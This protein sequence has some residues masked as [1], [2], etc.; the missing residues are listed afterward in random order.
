[1]AQKQ[2][3]LKHPNLEPDKELTA[4]IFITRYENNEPIKGAKVVLTI[5][6]GSSPKQEITAIATDTVGLYEI[7]LPPMP[8]G[9]YK[10]GV[11][12]DVSNSSLA[13]NFGA[14]QVK[15]TPVE[16]PADGTSWARTVLI[17]LGVLLLLALLGT[18][19]LVAVQ[20]GRREKRVK[21]ETVTA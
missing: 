18:L 8:Q 13:A 7:K 20:Y 11:H 10:L 21:E 19:L 14:V 3:T 15:V 17:I 4:R 16:V 9:D 1:M 12:I 2:V 5:E 6:G